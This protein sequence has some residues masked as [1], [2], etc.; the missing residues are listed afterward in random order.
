M[1]EI[2]GSKKLWVE[3]IFW[4]A[5]RFI[6]ALLVISILTF[7]LIY[8]T[9]GDPAEMYLR[10]SGIPYSVTAIEAIREEMGLNRPAYM[11]YF[12]WLGAVL[13]GDLGHSL[14]SREPVLEVLMAASVN[15]FKLGMVSMVWLIIGSLGLSIWSIRRPNG[16]ADN[17]IQGFSLFAVSMP[18]F[19]LGYVLILLFAATLHW[20]PVSG[21]SGDFAVILPSIALMIPMLGQTTLFLRKCFLDGMEEPHVQNAILRGVAYPY[22]VYNHLIKNAGAAIVTMWSWDFLRILTGSILIESVFAWPGIGSLFVKAAQNGDTPVIQGALLLFGIMAMTV[23]KLTQGI[24]K[25]LDP[26]QRHQKRGAL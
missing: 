19:F 25:W 3:H 13:Q 1:I 12:H 17:F 16:L 22:L 24:V 8:I 21:M 20:F 15:T 4:Y 7:L 18:S 14:M 11:Q 23:N 9:P 6:L 2:V 5:L 26:R 10:A